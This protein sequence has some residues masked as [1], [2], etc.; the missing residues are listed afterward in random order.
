VVPVNS[1]LKLRRNVKT[2]GLGPTLTRWRLRI[3]GLLTLTVAEEGAMASVRL[4]SGEKDR[5]KV[6]PRRSFL[7]LPDRKP[8]SLMQA[9]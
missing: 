5:E 2:T 4:M 6:R 8:N 1:S 7:P 9:E 3:L